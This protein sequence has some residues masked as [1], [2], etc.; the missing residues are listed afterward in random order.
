MVKQG[1]GCGVWGKYSENI[2]FTLA[3]RSIIIFLRHL[4]AFQGSAWSPKH[5]PMPKAKNTFGKKNQ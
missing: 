2:K 3:G 5:L 4:L 1:Q